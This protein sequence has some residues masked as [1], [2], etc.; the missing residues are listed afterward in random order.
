MRWRE[1]TETTPAPILFSLEALAAQTRSVENRE[2]NPRDE[3]SRWDGD[4]PCSGDVGTQTPTYCSELPTRAGSH[5][6]AG[7]HVSRANWQTEESR[8]L[9]DARSHQLGSHAC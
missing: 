3:R 1:F 4:D 5:H 6:C 2:N 9:D 8:A 7:D